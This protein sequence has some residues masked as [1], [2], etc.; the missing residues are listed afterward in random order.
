[1]NKLT[2]GDVIAKLRRFP[3][4]L[5]ITGMAVGC[6]NTEAEAAE[7]GRKRTWQYSAEDQEKTIRRA[8]I[9]MAKPGVEISNTE[10]L[11][12]CKHCGSIGFVGQECG[13][14][15]PSDGL[16]PMVYQEVL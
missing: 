14:C 12:G 4:D 13:N 8:V 16:G 9:R 3:S 1:M 2:V 15:S 10:T 11:G 7:D 6:G 5:V